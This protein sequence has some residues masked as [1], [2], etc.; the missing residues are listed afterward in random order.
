MLLGFRVSGF[1]GFGFGVSF[2]VE[3]VGLQGF[4]LP[5]LVP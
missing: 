3:G 5:N 4:R 1:W 2:E